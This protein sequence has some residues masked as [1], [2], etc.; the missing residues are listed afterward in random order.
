MSLLKYVMMCAVLPA[1][2]QVQASAPPSNTPLTGPYTSGPL[3]PLSWNFNQPAKQDVT[4][5]KETQYKIKEGH[6]TV[7]VGRVGLNKHLNLKVEAPLG[8]AHSRSMQHLEQIGQL[9]A[10]KAEDKRR[11]G[12]EVVY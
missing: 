12:F 11:L 5:Q 7:D 6:Q 3:T 2:S 9:G 8:S 10:D 4:W 1:V